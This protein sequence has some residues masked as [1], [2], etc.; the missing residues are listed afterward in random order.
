M[1]VAA[2]DEQDRAALDAAIAGLATAA[3][4]LRTT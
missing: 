4:S 3:Q 1:L 2:V